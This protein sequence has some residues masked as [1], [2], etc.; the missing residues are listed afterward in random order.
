M[1]V[2]RGQEVLLEGEDV[3]EALRRGLTLDQLNLQAGD[4]LMVPAEQGSWL[5]NLGVIVG[6]LGSLT[7][8]LGATR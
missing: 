6:I 7:F 1:R 5:A 4:Q 2:E 8:V 3:Q